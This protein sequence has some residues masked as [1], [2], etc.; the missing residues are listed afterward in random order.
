[1][2][3][4][5]LVSVG[6][7]LLAGSLLAGRLSPGLELYLTGMADTDEV[8]VML[9]M[10]EQADIAIMDE[11]L[12]RT[13]A[14][15][16]D[17][18]LQVVSTLQNTARTSQVDLLVDLADLKEQGVVAGW[19]SHWLSNMVI[20][21]ADVAT[22]R[23]LAARADVEQ[24]EVDLVVELIE[25]VEINHDAPSSRSVVEG[26]DNIE[27]DRVWYELGVFGE[28]ALVGCMDTGVMGSHVAFT[29]RWQGNFAPTSEAWL[30]L[31]GGNPTPSDGYGHG[32]H[33][34][35]TICGASS[36][37]IG[38]APGARWL[39]SN[40]IDQGVG[41]EFDNDVIAALEW[42]MNPDGD[43]FTTDDVPDVVQNSWRINEG[44]GYDYIDCD[45]RWWTAIDNCEAAG[46]VLTWSAGNEG[47]GSTTIGS[48]ADRASGPYN[49][50]SV[51]STLRYPPYT[52]SSFSSRGPSGCGGADAT[53]PEICAPGSDIYS[54]YNNGG[55]TTMS[56][57]SMAG[58]HIA[59]V[60]GLMRSAN[61]DVDVT[62]IKQ[63]IMDTAT[64]LGSTGED[65]TYGWGFVNAYEAVL[66]VM[67][68]YGSVEGTVTSVATG[69]PIAGAQVQNL[70]GP[71]I[72]YTN[73][74]GEYQLYI[75]GGSYTFEYSAEGF[76]SDTEWVVVPDDGPVFVD[77]ALITSLPVIAVDPDE[78]NVWLPDGGNTER[79]MTISNSGNDEL[80]YSL[81]LSEATRSFSDNM[82]NGTNG[83]T[84]S[85]SN[86]LWHQTTHRSN[87]ASHSWYCGS[88]GTWEYSN[89]QHS[90]LI[91]PEFYV[92][93]EADFTFS[94][95]IDAEIY[96]SYEAWDGGVVELSTDGSNWT[97]ITPAGGY[98]YTIYDNPAS[99]F[100]VGTP[101]YAG[102]DAGWS[103]ASFDLAAW[104]GQT[105]QVRFRFGS[106]GYV[107]EE[108]WY[109]DDVEIAGI[110]I[111]WLTLDPINGTVPPA[112]D[113]EVTLYFD[114]YGYADITLTGQIQVLSNDPISPQLVL[115]VTLI[116]GGA[117]PDPIDDLTIQYSSTL[118]NL[119]WSLIDGATQYHIYDS[120]ESYGP[121]TLVDTVSTNSWSMVLSGDKRFYHVTWE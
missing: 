113:D 34:M 23:Q 107:V 12:H 49:C 102:V 118:V 119:T 100:P 90:W 112:G 47:S 72:S 95:W 91:S 101:C 45:S 85:G 8:K 76:L 25:P 3:K 37:T 28:G 98:P 86:D 6:T 81:I 70:A 26:V 93:L 11:Q 68:G 114:A 31:L 9:S 52:I 111:D 27:A 89:D 22:V 50:F 69:L 57:T 24:A 88:E 99:P 116:V 36:D 43:I 82:E 75:A 30:D 7:L 61:P 5:T 109:I 15:L 46:C 33:V 58:P 71:E 87:S 2:K 83:W 51:G 10:T 16:A 13:R 19:T 21:R 105:A 39:A 18:Y 55:Y 108:G 44:F 1:M 62:T 77:M 120:S 97:Q 20:V 110:T 40:P 106:D 53:K 56:G 117:P 4:L 14:P 73:L 59:G 42:F 79:T 67:E 54:A 66:A 84:H 115:P 32:T 65:N 38:V 63:I 104:A 78:F 41:S 48:P 103:E 60:V 35:G 80:D 92:E 29:D 96:D 17:R 64:D 74:Y 94:H 121:W